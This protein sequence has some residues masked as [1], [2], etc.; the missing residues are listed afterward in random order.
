MKIYYCLL[1][2][3]LLLFSCNNETKQGDL[4]EIPVN[5]DQNISLSLSEIS[6]EITAIDLELTD[7]SLISMDYLDHVIVSGDDIF[8]KQNTKIFV[9]NKA[10]KFVRSIGSVG[11]GPGEYKYISTF[12]IDKKNNRLFV[13]S[14]FSPEKIICYDMNGKML[15]EFRIQTIFSEEVS[16]II[17][18]DG[19][20]LVISQSLGE[21]KNGQFKSS[22]IYRLDDDF[23]LIDSC[24]IRKD[25]FEGVKLM[26]S[27]TDVLFR[28]S[29]SI[30][31]YYREVYDSPKFSFGKEAIL[32]DT[33]YRFEK[34]KLIPE[35]K[36]KFKNDGISG[37]NKFIDLYSIYRSSRFIFSIY[38]NNLNKDR[39][40]FCYDTRTG[41]GYNMQDG[42]TDDIN[43]ID[44]PVKIR[45]FNLNTEMFYYLHTHM[46]PDDLEEPN[47]TLYIGRLKK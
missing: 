1:F 44:K 10:G 46:K 47:P 43:G 40:Y 35:L 7:K 21:D 30:G 38:E 3:G 20:L 24:K 17:Y 8:I 18:I 33:L 29:S 41:K 36:L 39:F 15:K 25:Y 26:S 12:T 11:Q 5:I 4:Q 37:G 2:V 22:T 9:F 28:E 32:R 45:P 19:E 13:L 27:V 16:E 14:C 42:Y 6:E 23:N 31:F 34:N